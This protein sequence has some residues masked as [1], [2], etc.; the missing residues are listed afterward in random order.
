MHSVLENLTIRVE[1]NPTKLLYAFLDVHGKVTH[2]YTYSEFL[3]R[4]SIIASHIHRVYPLKPGE[5]ILLAYP[6]GLEMICAFFACVRLGLIPVPVYPPSA[7]GFQSALYKMTFIANDCGA[8]AILTSNAYYWSMKLNLTRN[9]TVFSFKSDFINDLKWI[10]SDDAD[11]TSSSGFCEAHSDIL[12]LQYTSGSTNDPKG[13]M[14]THENIIHNCDLV[15][16]HIPIGVSWLPQ[17]H[18]MGLIGYYLFFALQGGTTYGFSPLDFIQRP[19]LWLETISKYKGTA[20]SAPNFAYAYCLK[21]GK[22]SEKAVETLNLSSLQFLMNAAEPVRT[23]TYQDFLKKFEPYGLKPKSFFSAYGLAE[24]TLAVSNYGRTIKLFDSE[25]LREDVVKLS[26]TDEPATKLTSLISCGKPLGNTAVKIVDISAIPRE[27]SEGKVGEI[28]IT[29]DSKCKGYWNRPDLSKK[30]FDATGEGTLSSKSW[31]RTGDLGF[32]HEGELF[33]CGRTKDLI[34]IRGLNYYPQDIE[35][36]VEEEPAIRKVAAFSIEKDCEEALVV[37]IELKN[38]KIIPDTQSINK[39]ILQHLGIGADVFVYVPSRTI[40]KTSSG[41]IIRHQTK[42]LFLENN[43]KVICQ[44]QPEHNTREQKVDRNETQN[45][46]NIVSH[47]ALDTLFQRYGLDSSTS[48]IFAEVGFDSLRLAEFSHDLKTYVEL[49]GYTDLSQPIEISLIQKIVV[50]ELYEILRGLSTASIQ[51]QFRFK[52]AFLNLQREH[53]KIE[54]ELMKRDSI[55]SAHTTLNG[56]KVELDLS[57]GHILLTGGTGFFGPFL[58]KSILEQNEE[59]IYVLVRAKDAVT[60]MSRLR[61]AFSSIGFTQDLLADF[62]K[63]VKPLCGDLSRPK[64]G[65]TTE[66]WDFLAKKIHTIYHNG[67]QVNY[68]FDYE[69][70]RSSNVVGT[71]EIVSLA[72][73]ARHKVVNHISTTFIFGWSVKETLFE[74]DTNEN[75]DLLDFGYSQ[76]KWVSEQIIK[77]SMSHGLE[78]RIF[79]PALISP[80]VSGGG[81]NFDISIRLL[82][83]MLKHGI[84]TTAQNQ[85]SFTPADIA[86]NNIVAISNIKESIGQTFHVTREEHSSMADITTVLTGLTGKK[87]QNFSLHDFVPEVVNRCQKDDLL[88][89]LLNFLVRSIDNIKS[90]EF[91][92]YDNTNYRQFCSQSCWGINDPPLEDV[93]LGI[94][95]FME[96]KGIIDQYDKKENHV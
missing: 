95:R 71:N 7:H 25:S 81:Y 83:F 37:V 39:K 82:A 14:V 3:H 65:I 51:S 46:K 20:S 76:S 67:A 80:A 55:P 16:D 44:V 93:V 87:F 73:S 63:R 18:D 35:S 12:F 32:I 42:K 31:L 85:V 38:P 60:G 15:V 68:L 54:Q 27:V 96:R 11:A 70:M 26:T 10:V 89:P 57:P 48:E 52:Q 8:A 94:L 69:S 79:R 75:M 29:G 77:Q 88:F 74:Y 84:G 90:M 45:L 43:L 61:E 23:N 91:K 28:W 86:S 78:A 5:R 6:P 62:E 17:Y 64:L 2:S 58:L 1:Q 56:M 36:I 41:K 59:D 33:I 30:I 50:S 21:P 53:K 66:Q 22:I 40:T 24:Y 92:R 9:K 19:A 49:R 4:T 13:V 34:I 72:R 47:N